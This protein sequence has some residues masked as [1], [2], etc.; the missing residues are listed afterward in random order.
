MKQ[1]KLF[2]GNELAMLALGFIFGF[3]LAVLSITF[4][5]NYTR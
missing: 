2:E 5:L 3:A 1:L 4:I